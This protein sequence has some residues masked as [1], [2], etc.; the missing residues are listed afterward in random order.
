MIST[1][2][3]DYAVREM[4]GNLGKIR[5]FKIAPLMKVKK[6]LGIKK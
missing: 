6:S 1:D 2:N 4:N 3:D 5:K